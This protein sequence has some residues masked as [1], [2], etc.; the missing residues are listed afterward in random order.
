MRTCHG[1]PGSGTRLNLCVPG[2][3]Q[4]WGLYGG[5][6]LPWPVPDADI[7]L[8]APT[9]VRG[10]LATCHSSRQANER[11]WHRTAYS[12]E[13]DDDTED[14]LAAE[15]EGRRGAL[16]SSSDEGGVGGEEKVMATVARSRASGAN[17]ACASVRSERT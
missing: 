11:E 4:T 15:S 14:L 8:A 2:L 7:L 9:C 13:V 16:P 5:V 10:L 6:R 17:A 1:P 12:R 3:Q